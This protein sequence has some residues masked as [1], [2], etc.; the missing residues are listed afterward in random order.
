MHTHVGDLRLLIITSNLKNIDFYFWLFRIATL[1]NSKF[2][3]VAELSQYINK[4]KGYLRQTAFSALRCHLIEQKQENCI[5]VVVDLAITLC[6]LCSRVVIFSYC[7]K[8]LSDR[9][10]KSS[11]HF[12]FRKR[13]NKNS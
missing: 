10:F 9:K 7:W 5:L 3:P 12:Y 4:N 8:S 2:V 11:K 1:T 13:E 6:Y